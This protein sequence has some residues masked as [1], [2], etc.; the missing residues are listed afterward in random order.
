MNPARFLS[1]GPATHS[2]AY[3]LYEAAAKLPIVSPQGYVDPRLFPDPKATFGMPAEL[4]I[5]PDHY[6]TRMLYM[7][8][9]IRYLKSDL[10]GVSTAT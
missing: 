2:I 7:P 5:N 3:D 4:F 6:V 8:V 9:T 10:H 1:P